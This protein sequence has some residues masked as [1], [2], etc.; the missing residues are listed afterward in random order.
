MEGGEKVDLEIR[1]ILSLHTQQEQITQSVILK[2][3]LANL[4]QKE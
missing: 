4:Q 3:N 2:M 1:N